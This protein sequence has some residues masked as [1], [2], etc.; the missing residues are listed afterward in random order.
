MPRITI[1]RNWPDGDQIRISVQAEDNHPDGLLRESARV[2][3][4]TYAEALDLTI[5]ADVIEANE[6]PDE[7]S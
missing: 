4:A 1:T 7:R 2:A 6:D 3:V 5:A